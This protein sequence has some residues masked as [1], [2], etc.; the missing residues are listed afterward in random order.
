MGLEPS[1]GER[2]N[3]AGPEVRG[4]GASDTKQGQVELDLKQGVVRS[5]PNWVGGSEV[6]PEMGGTEVEQG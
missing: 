5:D 3:E 6:Q 4:G 2:G 1:I